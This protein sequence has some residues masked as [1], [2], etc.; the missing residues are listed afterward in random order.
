MTYQSAS[1]RKVTAS[2]THWMLKAKGE[3]CCDATKEDNVSSNTPRKVFKKVKP[4]CKLEENPPFI[5]AKVVVGV[6]LL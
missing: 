2:H 4:R 6:D 3:K 5:L 1:R